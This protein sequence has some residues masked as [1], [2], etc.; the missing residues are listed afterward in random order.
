MHD[1]SATQWLGDK[2]DNDQTEEGVVAGVTCVML[3]L[4]AG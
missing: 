3:V 1:G 4:S 2:M